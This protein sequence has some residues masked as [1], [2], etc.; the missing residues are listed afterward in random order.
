MML[1]RQPLAARFPNENVIQFSFVA[2][3]FRFV[4]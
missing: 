1:Q 3:F 2:A 4:Q